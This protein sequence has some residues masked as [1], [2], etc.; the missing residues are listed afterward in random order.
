MAEAYIALGS[1]LDPETHLCEAAN[2]FSFL[3]TVTGV[4]DFYCNPAADRPD[5]PG[6]VNGM[7]RVETEF[8]PLAVKQEILQNL[9]EQLGRVRTEDRYAPRIIDLDLC[10]YG[11]MLINE[12]GLIL[13]DPELTRRPFLFIP[14]LDID[15]GIRFPGTDQKLADLVP[16]RKKVKG[17]RRDDKL[18]SIIKETLHGKNHP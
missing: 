15:P 10:L 2:L 16:P 9:E 6:F 14:V 3:F 7:I 18:T 4:S 5:Q 17:L 12:S 8:P 1:N 11:D 13:P